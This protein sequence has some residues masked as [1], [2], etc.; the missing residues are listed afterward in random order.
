MIMNKKFLKIIAAILSANILFAAFIYAQ[1]SQRAIKVHDENGQPITGALVY[2]GEVSRAVHTNDAGEFLIPLDSLVS[3]Y[4]EAEG[5]ESR[6]IDAAGLGGVNDVVLT[7]APYQMG[8]RDKVKMPFGVFT[9][10]SIP[11]AVTVLS[12]GEILTYD[13]TDIEGALTGRVPGMYGLSN[14]R[15]MANPLIVV[16]GIPRPAVD[17]NLQQIEQITVVKDL[18]TAMLYGSQA[19]NGVILVTTRRGEP[20]KKSIRFTAE[21]GFNRPISYPQYLDAANYMELYNEALANDGLTA[22]FTDEQIANTRSGIDPVRYPDESYF[23]S[24]YLND[25]TTYQNVVAEASGGNQTAQYYLNLGW[26]RNNSL[27]K[28]GEGED[29]KND[30]LNMRGNINYNLTK[31]ISL[32]FDGSVIFNIGRGPRYTGDDFWTLASTLHPE[33]YPVLIPANLITDPSLIG[34]AKMVNGHYVLGGTSEYMTNMYGELTLNGNT[35]SNSRLFEMS[36]GLDFDLASITQGLTASVYFSFDIFNQYIAD[37]LN[38]YAVYSPMYVNDSISFSKY[39]VDLK[40]NEPTIT[41]STFYRR[42]GVYGILDYQRNFGDHEINAVGLIYRDQ[43]SVDQV[44]QPTKH[45]HF[46]IRANYMYQKRFIAELTGVLAGSSKLFETAPYAF[47]PGIG[48]GWILSEENFLKNNAVINYLKVRANWAINN[49]D[50]S[51]SAYYTGRNIYT[52]GSTFYYDQGIYSNDLRY[53]SNGNPELGWNKK[54]NIN[55]GFETMLFNYKFGF[56][57]SYFYDKSYNLYST[58]LNSIPVYYVGLPFENYGSDK[59][60]GIEVGLNYNTVLRD[61]G[62]RLGGNMVYAVPEV[63]TRDELNYPDEY[64]SIIGKP[65]DAMFGFVD[66]GL[67]QDQTEINN[68]PLQTFSKVQPGDI[69]YKDLN[70][71]NIIDDNDQKMIGNSEPRLGYGLTANINYKSFELFIL[72]TGQAGEDNI[73][74]DP[75]YWVYGNRKYSEVVLDRWTPETASTASYPRLSSTSNANNF[76][77]STYWL[78]K[79]NWFRLQTIQLTYTLMNVKFAGLD[80]ARFFVRG[81]N[82]FKISK[83]KD[84]TDLNIGSAPQTRAIS[85]GLALQF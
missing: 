3:I 41:N 17:L 78:Y 35:L 13:Q 16:D 10:R 27:L 62:I 65:T 56:E 50:E 45:L 55:F 68:S 54:M 63:L 46:G 23:N 6:I 77:N 20:L 58:L 81:H 29:E 44:F 61:I 64:R 42:T 70:N 75:Y 31:A 22:K 84:K 59:V 85:I 66:D 14:L 26:H 43:N 80:E 32:R 30:R 73:F 19:S 74:N 1:E 82:L 5:F 11:G 49:S 34:A 39:G 48:L 9:R 57:A 60:H 36:T 40:V 33:Y 2:V 53:L 69:K 21:N 47:S 38:S 79:N 7:R 71:D 83:I 25:W 12:P 51:L 76:V 52:A 37:L 8:E 15:G 28:V 72:A 67:F 24:T 4:I 18:S